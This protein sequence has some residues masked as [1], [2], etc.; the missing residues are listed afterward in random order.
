VQCVF[1][2]MR[3]SCNACFVQCVFR[4]MRVSC[5]ACFVQCMLR[6]M[7]ASCNA[8]FVQCMFRAMRVSCNACFV[9][10]MLRTINDGLSKY[11]FCV[12]S[13]FPGT[14]PP[15][16]RNTQCMQHA[17]CATRTARNL[18]GVQHALHAKRIVRN[19]HY[20]QN[21][22]CASHVVCTTCRAQGVLSLLLPHA[23]NCVEF[24]ITASRRICLR[25]RGGSGGERSEKPKSNRRQ[26]ATRSW[27]TGARERGR[28]VGN[29]AIRQQ[30]NFNR[31]QEA[32]NPKD[33]SPRHV[34]T[35]PRFRPKVA[36]KHAV[37]VLRAVRVSAQCVFP[38]SACYV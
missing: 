6:A 12:N 35:R 25:G 18:H 22:L 36:R 38:C 34:A 26:T 15:S 29:N 11:L 20:M 31:D 27:R 30:I 37:R 21:A 23:R 24:P 2:A 8:C 10:C 28:K 19:M 14:P 16:A 33:R 7:R 1:R 3:V 32:N 5:N 9:Q 4:A 17:P 13:F